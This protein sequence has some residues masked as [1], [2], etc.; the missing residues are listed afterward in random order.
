MPDLV[1]TRRSLHGVAELLLAGPQH[2]QSG[3]IRMAPCRGGFTTVAEPAVSV[4]GG[5]VVHGGRSERLH[6]RTVADV[7]A[8]IGLTHVSLVDVY[9]DGSGIQADD[10]LEV[11]DEA[12]AEIA[13]AFERGQAGLEVFRPDIAAVLWPEHFDLGI[14]ADEVNYGISPGDDHVAVPYAYVGP[15]TPREGPFWN[16]SFGAARPLSEIPDL[17]AWF[18]EGAEHARN[19][20]ARNDKEK[21]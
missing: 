10:V 4:V 13:A 2:A 20:H 9:Q 14:T 7:A 19:D 3:T 16:T 18:A 21:Q 6:G 8:A 12:A 17:A 11:S 15:W 5:E 1:A